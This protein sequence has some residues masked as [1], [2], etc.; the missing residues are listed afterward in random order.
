ME[1]LFGIDV[2][3]WQGDFDFAAAIKEGV[4]FA[5]LKGG[6]ADDGLY[7]DSRFLSSYTKA[8][9]LGL[10]VGVY[11]FSR[12]TTVTEAENEAEFF[13]D[14]V[15][16]GRQFELPVYIDVEHSDMLSLG[17]EVLTEIIKTWCRTLENKKLWVG[18]YASLNTFENYVNDSKL[19]Q[20]THWV[21]QWAEE[22]TYKTPSVLDMWQFGGSTNLLRSNVVAG[23]ICDQNY[24]LTNLPSYIMN[25][26]YNGFPEQSYSTARKTV[27]QI[28]R[29]IVQ[30]K[31]GVGQDRTNRLTEAGY[32][33]GEVDAALKAIVGNTD[34]GNTDIKVGDLVRMSSDGVIFGTDDR[35]A[36]FVYRT[37]LYVREKDGQRAVIST[38]PEGAVTGAVDVAYLT[39]HKT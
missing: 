12:A 9:K 6:G 27:A 28:A 17:K 19:T 15:I 33:L 21:A 29:E 26:G 37:L 32:D 30:G 38:Q 31:W 23:K 34:T 22:C 25:L 13:Y 39:K 11:W 20:Y 4:T 16:S 35:F 5:I 14:N 18:I 24:M 1:R 8:K 2:S 7:T 10:P 3:M 36:D